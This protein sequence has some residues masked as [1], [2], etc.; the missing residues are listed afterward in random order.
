VRGV[1]VDRNNTDGRKTMIHRYHSL[2]GCAGLVLF[3]IGSMLGA[4]QVAAAPTQLVTVTN[5][6]LPVQGTVSVGN[7]VTTPLNVRGVDEPA[8]QPFV[9]FCGLDAAALASGVADCLPHIAGLFQS[10]GGNVPAGKRFVIETVSGAF[11][12]DPGNRPGRIMLETAIANTAGTHSYFHATSEGST[13][14]FAGETWS[15]IQP[16]RLYADAGNGLPVVHVILSAVPSGNSSNFEVYLIG[17]LV[18]L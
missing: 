7:T 2:V 4:S 6:P 16:V 8:R 18:N 12:G 5:T 1:S 10:Q 3:G 15:F 14:C 17:Y 13:C 11:S 9:M